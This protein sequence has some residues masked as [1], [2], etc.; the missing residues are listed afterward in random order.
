MSTPN[1][2]EIAPRL[3]P[4]TLSAALAK[5]HE[6]GALLFDSAPFDVLLFRG[7]ASPDIMHELGRCREITFRNAGQGVGQPL[8]LSP[9]DDYYH[10]LVLWD[11][12]AGR[13][14]GAY[15]IGFTAQ[16]IA[17]HGPH[18][19]YLD[20][21]FDIDPA[22]FDKLGPAMEL[23]RS[24]VL[25]DYQRDNRALAAL[26]RG[27]G[28]AAVREK[29]PTMFGSVTISDA[30]H[31]A[32]QTLLVNCLQRDHFD[33][34]TLPSLVKPRIPFVPAAD[35]PPLALEHA[36][37]DISTLRAVVEE[38]EGGARSIPPLIRY[39]LSVGARFL[40][41]HV[42]PAFNN[43]IYCLLRVNLDALDARYRKRF[44]GDAG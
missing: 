29:C 23:S 26:W 19:L 12:V 11:S 20:H 8:D 41:F 30:F 36:G 42:E 18:G 9:E 35:L 37:S 31:R 28:A 17:D 40:A 1:K 15:R 27:L 38:L 2:P 33:D 6:Q 13:L 25:P 32:S 14:A 21:V 44:L 24:F 3:A 34:S 22:F 16:I 10:H 7:D 4:E 39:Y 5:L 43:A